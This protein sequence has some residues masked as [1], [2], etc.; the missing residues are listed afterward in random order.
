MAIDKEVDKLLAT[1]FIQEV[2]YSYWLA[3]IMMVKK[4]NSKWRICIDY[5]DLNKAC[6]KDNFSLFKI[7]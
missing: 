4:A 1:D 5:I 2:T 6:L 3:N 7:D